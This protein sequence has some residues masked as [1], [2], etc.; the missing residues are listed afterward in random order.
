[1]HL[2]CLLGFLSFLILSYK[3]KSRNLKWVHDWNGKQHDLAIFVCL[4][5]L[6]CNASAKIVT[7]MY[8]ARCQWSE[9]ES[10][11]I[12]TEWCRSVGASPPC[13][14]LSASCWRQREWARGKN[15]CLCPQH[16]SWELW[17]NK[18][19]D[20]SKYAFNF[21]ASGIAIKVREITNYVIS[22][23]VL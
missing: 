12:W 17:K 18:I 15:G 2:L 7:V 6:I 5:S 3:W 21:T 4:D 9:P 13:P 8:H 23:E 20:I 22:S 19:D 10:W 14:P 16:V 1:M 11:R